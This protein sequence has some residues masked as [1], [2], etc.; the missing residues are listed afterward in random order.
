M[1]WRCIDVASTL[2][3]CHVPDGSDLAEILTSSRPY[4]CPGYLQVWGSSDQIKAWHDNT[5]PLSCHGEIHVTLSTVTKC[6]SWQSQTYHVWWQSVEICLRLSSNENTD[7][8]WADNSVKTWWNLPIS[9]PQLDIHNINGENSLIFTQ[10]IFWKRIIWTC[11][12]KITLSKSNIFCP[13][14]IPNHISTVSVH[15]PGSVKIYWYLLK[16]S[17]R[18]QTSRA[19]YSVKKW[20]NPTISNPKPDLHNINAHTKFGD[21]P[22]TFTRYHPEMK[23]QTDR[24]TTDGW[25]TNLKP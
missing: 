10:V 24:H 13:L 17:S 5:L 16:L 3:W 9:N 12:R 22:F 7:V 15:L 6:T 8:S 11:P 14:A 4:D 1:S 20:Q 23:I 18:K 21:N 25:T 2:Y 19:D